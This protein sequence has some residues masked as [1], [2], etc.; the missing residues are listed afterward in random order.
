VN[1]YLPSAVWKLVLVWFDDWKNVPAAARRTWWVSLGWGLL[2]TV[3]LTLVLVLQ[4]RSLERGGWLARESAALVALEAAELI[5]FN[6]AIWLDVF[7]NG[8]VLTAMIFVSAGIAAS[9]GRPLIAI[10]LA[11]GYL[12]LFIPVVLGWLAWGRTRPTIIASGIGSPGGLLSS[13]PSG[14]L[15]QAVVAFGILCY[16]WLR[17]GRSI[18]ERSV[19]CIVYLLL[20]CTVVLAR[21][22]LGAHWPSD[23]IAGAVI[24]FFW[25]AMV[26]RALRAAEKVS[27]QNRPRT[28][29]LEQHTHRSSPQMMFTPPP[30]CR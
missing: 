9:R 28:V 11:L 14:H 10:A 27:A 13:F 4:T 7:G 3:V 12:S 23:M 18:A 16:L 5:S 29:E 2:A 15:V 25:L 8:F 26:V 24:G 19:T 22:R 21:L 30:S 20:V 1:W 17:N 6:D